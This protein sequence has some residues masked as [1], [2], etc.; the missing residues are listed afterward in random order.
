MS[1]GIFN[2]YAYATCLHCGRIVSQTAPGEKWRDTANDTEC[3][4]APNPEEGPMPPHLPVS[5]VLKPGGN[6]N[7]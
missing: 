3:D 1:A 5:I 4:E 2:V 7:A 6:S